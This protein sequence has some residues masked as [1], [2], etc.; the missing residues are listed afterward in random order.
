MAEDDDIDALKANK[1][2]AR[3]GFYTSKTQSIKVVA[4]RCKNRLK[5]DLKSAKSAG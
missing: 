1:A 4:V 3:A 5:R 2:K